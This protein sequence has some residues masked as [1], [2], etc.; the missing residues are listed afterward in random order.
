MKT[1]Y[2]ERDIDDLQAAGA[3]EIEVDDDV[4]LTDLARERALKMGLRV[5][6]VKQRSGPPVKGLPPA[7]AAAI[8]AREPVAPPAASPPP[9]HPET[10][11][12]AAA[13]TASQQANAPASADETAKK[14]KA[15]VVAR[16]GTDRYNDLLDEIIP[17]VLARLQT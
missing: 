14:I 7:V 3:V 11:P 5:R 17:Q 15:A 6:R 8:P 4:V 1:F 2:T 12:P 9:A 10:M 16:L 13:T